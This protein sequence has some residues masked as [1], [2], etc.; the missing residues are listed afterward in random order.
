MEKID[1]ESFLEQVNKCPPTG[2][3]YR[4]SCI[5]T[6]C[7]MMRTQR[8]LMSSMRVNNADINFVACRELTAMIDTKMMKRNTFEKMGEGHPCRKIELCQ[9]YTCNG[10]DKTKESCD[11]M[12]MEKKMLFVPTLKQK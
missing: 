5:M 1:V 9:Y 6:V 7:V 11:Y 12:L 8:P 2:T 4:Q 10:C 3:V